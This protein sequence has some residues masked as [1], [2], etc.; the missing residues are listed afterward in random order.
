MVGKVGSTYSLSLRLVDVETGR[1]D[2][3]IA[4][5]VKG[6]PD[7]LLDAIRS[8]ARQLAAKYGAMRKQAP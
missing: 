2:A 6:D 8:G 7:V 4:V 3:A 1:I 5:D